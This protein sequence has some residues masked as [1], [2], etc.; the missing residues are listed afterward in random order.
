MLFKRRCKKYI[1]KYQKINHDN[2]QKIAGYH[3]QE[4]FNIFPA[5]V[6][7]LCHIYKSNS[8]QQV[9]RPTTM[10][11]S[12]TS[13]AITSTNI[14]APSSTSYTSLLENNHNT[15][16]TTDTYQWKK[17]KTAGPDSA[18]CNIALSS[19]N[20]GD[21]L[22]KRIRLRPKQ[23]SLEQLWMWLDDVQKVLKYLHDLN[24]YHGNINTKNLY[25][26]EDSTKTSTRLAGGPGSAMIGELPKFQQTDE[27]L[28]GSNSSQPSSTLQI[29]LDGNL[30]D[31]QISFMPRFDLN[32]EP[33]VKETGC[34]VSFPG[35][36]DIP[37][38]PQ[39]VKS[40]FE[41]VQDFLFL[42]K[43]LIILSAKCRIQDHRKSSNSSSFVP[44]WVKNDVKIPH[45]DLL[46]NPFDEMHTS[47][48]DNSVATADDFAAAWQTAC[49]FIDKHF[50]EPTTSSSSTTTTSPVTDEEKDDGLWRKVCSQL[51]R[52]VFETL[53]CIPVRSMADWKVNKHEFL[54]LYDE[55]SKPETKC[56]TDFCDLF[57]NYNNKFKEVQFDSLEVNIT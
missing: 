37:G 47:T 42:M 9:D 26:L 8:S 32:S 39:S 14:D 6:R 23:L 52:E 49:D 1:S 7:S 41:D 54:K 2:I 15:I 16:R 10:T 53:L 4:S 18:C 13:S 34:V 40:A 20:I 38:K 57:V 43:K 45:L 29:E 21:S 55:L 5:G 31:G 44:A 12:V 36:A 30:A 11:T 56:C 51:T 27:P 22:D 17:H 24:I 25:V 35:F 28:I 48:F 33:P 19:N 50:E 46:N 3:I